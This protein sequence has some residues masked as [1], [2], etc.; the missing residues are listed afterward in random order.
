MDRL[1]DLLEKRL[2]RMFIITTAGNMIMGLEELSQSICIY[3]IPKSL[4]TI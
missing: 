3:S 2:S 4:I 1:P